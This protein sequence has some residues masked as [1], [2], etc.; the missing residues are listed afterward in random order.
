LGACCAANRRWWNSPADKLGKL[1]EEFGPSGSEK[2]RHNPFWHLRT[3]GVWQL[4]GPAEI[5]SCP[6][7]GTPTITELRRGRVV[8]GFAEPGRASQPAVLLG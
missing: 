7:G 2:T 5:T 8:G 3:D 4:A 1:L 6:A